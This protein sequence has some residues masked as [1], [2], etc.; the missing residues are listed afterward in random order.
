VRVK[1]L[2]HRRLDL[3]D[4]CQRLFLFGGVHY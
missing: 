3:L 1:A 2:E 4:L